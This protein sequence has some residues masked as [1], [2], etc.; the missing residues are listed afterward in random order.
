MS[1][2]SMDG[3]DAVLVGFRDE[4]CLIHAHHHRDWPSVGTGY[5]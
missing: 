4:R 3:I 2:T 1:G 5:R